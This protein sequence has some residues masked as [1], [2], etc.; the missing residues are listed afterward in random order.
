MD[1]SKGFCNLP[2]REHVGEDGLKHGLHP[3]FNL[4]MFPQ[5][6]ELSHVG[7]HCLN[8][9]LHPKLYVIMFPWS[10]LSDPFVSIQILEKKG[11][12]HEP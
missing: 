6:S 8:N 9:F 10:S 12:R 5:R 7:E 11:R 4:I 2:G 3:K 1:P